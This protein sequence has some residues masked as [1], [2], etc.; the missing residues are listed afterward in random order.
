MRKIYFIDLFCGAGG[1]S[2][3][4]HKARYQGKQFAHVLACVNHDANAIASH[5]SNHPDTLHFTE[6]IRILDLS[7]IEEKVR[8]IRMLEPDAILILWAS[9]ECTNFS[10]AKGGQPRDADSRTLAEHLFRYIEI[11]KPDCIWI[12]NVREFMSWG[13]L[14]SKGKPISKSKGC[15]YVRWVQNVQSYGYEYGHKLLNSADY[16]AYTSRTRYFAQFNSPGIP[17][18][19][20]EPTHSKKGGTDMFSSLKPWNA[21]RECLDFSDEGKSIFERKKDLSEKTLERIYAGLVKY[22]AGGKDS[23]LKQYNSGTPFNRV[24]SISEPCNTVTTENRFAFVR[25]SFLSKYYS[26][27]PESKN[28]SIEDPADS[29]TTIDHHSVVNADFIA[30]YYGNG[31]NVS[32]INDPAGTLTTKDR[33][34][35][36]KPCYFIDKTYT[37]SANHQSIEVPAGTILTNDKHQLVRMNFIDKQ[38][39]QGGKN[40]S[41]DQPSGTLLTVPKM[42]LVTCKK[43]IMNTNFSNVGTSL[44][45]P[46]PVITA[47]RK[48]HYLMNPQYFSAG[49]NVEKPCFTLIARMDKMP[50]YLIATES[51]HIAIEVYETDSPCM[52]KIKEFMA[53]YGII[54]IKMRMLMV[55]ELLKIQGFPEDYVLIGTQADKK[56]FIGNS[57]V[58]EVVTAMTE[59]L[60]SNGIKLN[61]A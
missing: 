52:R 61:V 48:W 47:N 4:V 32:S 3:G 42:S 33:M 35:K 60:Y 49:G 46:A 29:I 36:V 21:V 1:T 38:F 10:N 16:G 30:K 14:D 8:K 51:G 45:E 5:A 17:I 26:G 24:K 34:I 22:V 11:I 25:C 12:E 58:P 28:K 50:P 7:L 53:M 59:A 55:K 19:W 2:T 56:K 15:D 27:H 20:P 13:P 23:F 6:D 39:S 18:V 40:Q 37:G 43:W 57:V 31:E 54:D 44:E 9:L 41:I